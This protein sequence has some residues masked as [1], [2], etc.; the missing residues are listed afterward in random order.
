MIGRPGGMVRV[1]VALIV[2]HNEGDF[3]DDVANA[4]AGFPF[5]EMEHRR[6]KVRANRDEVKAE[7]E[8]QLDDLAAIRRSIDPPIGGMVWVD[9]GNVN[10]SM[11][12]LTEQLFDAVSRERNTHIPPAVWKRVFLDDF[13]SNAL[14]HLR[15]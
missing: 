1:Q 4:F 5:V 6:V 3:D 2:E 12:V 8:R 9:D 7:I 13:T 10:K 15:L 11:P 14:R